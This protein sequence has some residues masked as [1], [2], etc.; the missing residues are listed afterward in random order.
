MRKVAI[1]TYEFGLSGAGGS[2]YEYANEL[3]RRG[4]SI[5][6]FCQNIDSNLYEIDDHLKNMEIYSFPSRRL[7]ALSRKVDELVFRKYPVRNS[8][9]FV[10]SGLFEVN[11]SKILKQWRLISS[12]VDEIH[13]HWPHYGF[14]SIK[15][16]N[17]ILQDFNGNSFWH[18][19]DL[20]LGQDLTHMPHLSEFRGKGSWSFQP[21]KSIIPMLF[22]AISRKRKEKLIGNLETITCSSSYIQKWIEN[23]EPYQSLFKGKLEVRSQ[24][25]TRLISEVQ[26]TKLASF[27]EADFQRN[28]IL[29]VTSSPLGYKRKNVLPALESFL[30]TKG[31]K[32]YTCTIVCEDPIF[33][34]NLFSSTR[35]N[36]VNFMPKRRLLEMMRDSRAV[37]HPTIF[38]TFGLA[39]LE[40]IALNPYV[41]LQNCEPHGGF[42]RNLSE[43]VFLGDFDLA[44]TWEKFFAFIE[45]VD[46]NTEMSRLQKLQ[47][48]QNRIIDEIWKRNL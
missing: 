23:N 19:H 40:S 10:T 26:Q 43:D 2:A 30:G 31:L 42:F 5:H 35:L 6:I 32:E 13:F 24:P 37:V 47:S 15:S 7:S 9:E 11:Q 41:G 25:I 46:G 17:S 22:A 18:L 8:K 45:T 44:Q 39:I 14:M 36:F 1:F 27:D 38:E 33:Y 4:Y 28:D 34:S 16:M 48:W 21:A 29:I 20:W 12:S 3:R